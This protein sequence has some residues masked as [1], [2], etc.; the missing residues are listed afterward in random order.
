[1]ISSRLVLLCS[2]ASLLASCAAPPAKAP[3][4]LSAP[5]VEPAR[6]E[7]PSTPPP[8]PPPATQ[9]QAQKIAVAAADLLEAGNEEQAKAELTRVLAGDPSNKL[10]QN[11]LRQISADPVATLGRESFPYTVRSSDTL[12]RIAGRF[13]GDIYSFYILARYNDIKIPRQVAGGQVIRIPGKAPPPGTLDNDPRRSEKP[14]VVPSAP[15]TPPTPATPTPPEPSAG[16]RALTAAEAAE[17][18]GDLERAY[19]EYRR[20]TSSDLGSEAAGR[21][22]QL[23]QRLVTRHTLNARIAFAKQDLDGSIRQ[24]DRVLQLDPGNDTARLEQ[25]KSR[26]LKEKVKSLK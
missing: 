15:A 19:T 4:P 6:I 9:Q 21:A 22:E 25:Q 1:M 7:A 23:R 26:A 5:A 17:R 2:M 10:A 16:D 24:W 12:S 14:A 8:P 11:L 13:L 3:A 18:A 20:A